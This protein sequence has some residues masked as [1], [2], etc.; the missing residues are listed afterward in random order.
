MQK[1]YYYLRWPRGRGKAITLSY[2]DGVEQDRQLVA[3]MKKHGFRGTFNLNYGKMPPDGTTY[4]PGRI[5]R[6]MPLSEC[7]KTF[8]DPDVEVAIHGLTHPFL[9]RL[10]A[11]EVMHEII[12]DR[13]GL[14]GAFGGVIRGMAYPY[15][16]YS[17]QV[18]EV[19]RLCGVCYA[20]TVEATQRFDIPKDWLRM[21]ATCHHVHPRLMELADEFDTLQVK[22]DPALFYLWGHSYE[23]E[24][25]NNWHVIEQFFIRLG[26]KDDI[27][28][29]TNIEVYDY[30]KAYEA[31]RFS[32]DGCRVQNTTATDVWLGNDQGSICIP[33]GKTVDL[34]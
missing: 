20:R 6:P 18:V 13:K 7:L 32:A 25:D 34:P 1:A 21:P 30:V 29:A 14:E 5:H 3:L 19:L 10:T 27:W 28:Y 4:E 16:T 33:A 15:G 12:E 24:R 9:E 17:D 31:L 2:D 22:K 8:S 11:P 26:G 23:F